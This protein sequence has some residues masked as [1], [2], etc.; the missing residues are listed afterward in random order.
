[1]TYRVLASPEH[2][3]GGNTCERDTL[4]LLEEIPAAYR[5]PLAAMRSNRKVVFGRPHV[6]DLSFVIDDLQ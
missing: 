1:M 5:P 2:S 4:E 3:F 6:P